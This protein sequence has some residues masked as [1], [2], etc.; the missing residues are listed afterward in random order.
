MEVLLKFSVNQNLILIKVDSLD[1]F[2]DQGKC[3]QLQINRRG[4]CVEC[5]NG[6]D[7][8]YW[9]AVSKIHN[10]QNIYIHS[11]HI[12]NLSYNLYFGQQKNETIY[13]KFLPWIDW[14]P[15]LRKR[16]TSIEQNGNMEKEC[17]WH[18]T[19]NPCFSLKIYLLHSLLCV[20]Y[21]I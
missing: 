8:C 15:D 17:C 21:D 18:W 9:L 10:E 4:L 16:K 11:N 14:H 7:V 3:S 20:K 13:Q 12:F 19:V 6:R 2:R 5:Y 1:T